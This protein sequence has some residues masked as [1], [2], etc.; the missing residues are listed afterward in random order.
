M[1][2]HT[3]A[4]IIEYGAASIAAGIREHR[5]MADLG[6]EVGRLQLA[7]HTKLQNRMGEPDL[8]G[9][10]GE[11]KEATRRLFSVIAQLL[12]DDYATDD[13]TRL[14]KAMHNHKSDAR[15]EYLRSLDED[16]EEA[17][18]YRSIIDASPAD[19]PSAAVAAH[20]GFSLQGRRDKERRTM[21]Q[22]RSTRLGG[23]TPDERA[24]RAIAVLSKAL[25]AAE[26]D[27]IRGLRGKR[28]TDAR[29]ALRRAHTA[30]G[31]LVKAV[32]D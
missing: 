28:R 14:T 22:V 27:D 11:A 13:M 1:S 12:P 20:Y 15:A 7:M 6:R 19:T 25:N 32:E 10:S 24:V 5:H 31:E 3:I 4:E 18:L 29:K 21:Q 30:V 26:A 8:R 2:P 23:A 9:V 16:S 17:E